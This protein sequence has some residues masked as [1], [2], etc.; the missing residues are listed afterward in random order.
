[1]PNIAILVQEAFIAYCVDSDV[2]LENKSKAEEIFRLLGKPL[3][4]DEG[5]MDAITAL[6]GCAPAYLSVIL[7]ALT[8]AGLKVGL[9]RDLALSL[10]SQAM[11]GTGKLVLEAQK[12]PSEIK[13]MVTTPGGVTIEGLRELEKIQIKHAIMKAIEAATMKSR[14][15]TE[16]LSSI[17]N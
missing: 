16:E 4:L 10:S 11:I 7:E 8:Y 5:F 9:P 14:K 2:T 6:S 13:D 12:T 3:E 15:I 17:K 1:M